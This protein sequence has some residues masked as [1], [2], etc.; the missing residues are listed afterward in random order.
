M[1]GPVG[2]SILQDD[3]EVDCPDKLW[4]ATIP[5]SRQGTW[6]MSY[7]VPSAL[8]LATAEIKCL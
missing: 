7:G 4:V 1:A 6:I 2:L 3:G 5:Y 8:I